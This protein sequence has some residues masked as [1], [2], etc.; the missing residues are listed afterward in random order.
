MTLAM[1]G[2]RS[3]RPNKTEKICDLIIGYRRLKIREIAETVSI[4]YEQTRNI[5][6]NELGFSKISARW[7]PRLLSVEQK[8]NRLA[9]SCDCLELFEADPQPFLDK[10]VTMD[11]TWVHQ[12]TPEL[13]QQ[14]KQWKRAESSF[15]KKAKKVLSSN[16]VTAFVFW[17][18]KSVVLI[19]YLEKDRTTNSVYFCIFSHRLHLAANSGPNSGHQHFFR[20]SDG[21][22][23]CRTLVFSLPEWF[24]VVKVIHDRVICRPWARL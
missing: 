14:P 17:N 19:D 12:Y 16:K 11:D 8:R 4:S 22:M 10:F 13:K 21:P 5:I 18:S 7:V 1:D 6:V 3:Q 24:A 2:L 20:H 15:P 23:Q 9:I